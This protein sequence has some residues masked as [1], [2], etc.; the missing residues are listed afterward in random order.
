VPS[1]TTVAS[2]FP[3]FLGRHNSAPAL[4]VSLRAALSVTSLLNPGPHSSITGVT[5]VADSLPSLT[6]VAPLLG[7]V[8]IVFPHSCSAV[9]SNPLTDPFCLHAWMVTVLP[10][11]LFPLSR[12]PFFFI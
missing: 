6:Q 11:L 8:H 9:L 5:G 2:W 3:S 1:P 10:S 7:W 12:V 4:M